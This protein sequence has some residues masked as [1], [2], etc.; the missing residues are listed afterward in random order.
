V[1]PERLPQVHSMK[2]RA[3]LAFA[4]LAIPV[5]L[6]LLW[7]LSNHGL[8][9]GDGA[10]YSETA[11]RIARQFSHGPLAAAAALLDVRGWR[12]TVFSALAAPIFFLT[13]NDLVAG[14]AA[15]LILIYLATIIY[16]Y[17][18]VLLWT[19]DPLIAAATSSAVLSMPLLVTYSL[20]FFSESAWILFSI[21]CVYHL[22]R[23]G[24][25]RTA[26]HAIIAGLCGAMTLAIRPV[27][28]AVILG[29]LLP[30]ILVPLIRFKALRLPH[31]L[32][33]FGMFSI[34]FAVLL[35]STWT[36]RITRLH[37]WA[38][39]FVA[40]IFS[41]YFANRYGRPFA[42]FLA[43]LTLGSCVWWAGYMAGLKLWFQ[44]SYDYNQIAHVTNMR[45][46]GEIV[47]ALSKQVLEDGEL[48]WILLASLAIFC[49]VSGI[50]KRKPIQA[51]SEAAGM[52]PRTLI[53]SASALLLAFVAIYSSGGSDRRRALVAFALFATPLVA[54]AASRSR[55]ALASVV[56]LIAVQCTTL[57]S[58]TAQIPPPAWTWRNTA[59]IPSPI[60]VDH[61]LETAQILAKYVT[62]GSNIAV[63]TTTLFGGPRVYEPNTLR[64]ICLRENLGFTPSSADAR[65]SYGELIQRFRREQWKYVLLDSLQDFV[66][67]AVRE[68]HVQATHELQRRLMAGNTPGL[69]TIG[70]FEMGGRQHIIFRVV[71][72]IPP[73]DKNNLAFDWN[74]ARAIATSQQNGFAI[75]DLNDGTDLPWG[76]QDGTNDL[77]AGVVLPAPHAVHEIQLRL[78]TPAG[79]A[80][81]RNIRIVAADTEGPDGPDWK[82]VRAR[83][84]GATQFTNLLTVPPL[85]DKSVVSIEVD[86]HDPED[87]PRRIWG[88]ACLRSQGDIPNYIGAQ[89]VYLRE[90]EMQ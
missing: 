24:P 65:G 46:A 22:L 71:P 13:G 35:L 80:H 75:A 79:R 57:A 29:V 3:Y 32:I 2:P 85:P 28:A 86:T 50:R 45:S 20:V 19:E 56:A 9:S 43:A 72:E 4:L 53:Y 11:M 63:F 88:F 66:P 21:A 8:Q 76:S 47:Q 54:L 34:P 68:P 27:E 1:L 87:H 82:F 59:G 38:I 73:A 74:G 52:W 61:N 81:M 6:V 31:V 40:V 90:L 10:D 89:G 5:L 64:I 70:R 55:I 16:L 30:F 36:T 42:M 14:P 7:H 41:V 48:Q 67:G 58:T 25:F 17:R 49:V 12:P 18:L 26:G 62:T 39:C 37:I 51:P 33:V 83:I 78:F 15:T 44:I 60:P 23:S 69:K 77:Y 84:K